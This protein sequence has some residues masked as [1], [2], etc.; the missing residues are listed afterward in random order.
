MTSVDVETKINI[1]L[2]KE[3]E[4]DQEDTWIVWA[5]S[6]KQRMLLKKHDPLKSLYI[7]GPFKMWMQKQIVEYFV[8]KSEEFREIDD[9]ARDEDN[10]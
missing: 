1:N 4:N 5:T 2:T 6:T 10:C 9:F 8:L 7:E 3:I